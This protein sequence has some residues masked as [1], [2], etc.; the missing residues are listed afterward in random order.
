MCMQATL[1]VRGLHCCFS[2]CSSLS[3]DYYSYHAIDFCVSIPCCCVIKWE[4]ALSSQT[5]TI[6]CVG[7]C[8]ETCECV[9]QVT[10]PSKLTLIVY[11]CVCMDMCVCT[12]RRVCEC[13][14]VVFHCVSVSLCFVWL[15]KPMCSNILCYWFLHDYLCTPCFCLIKWQRVLSHGTCNINSI[16][17]ITVW[18]YNY[19]MAQTSGRVWHFSSVY[20]AAVT[21]VRNKCRT[22]SQR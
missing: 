19:I 9:C 21:W 11:V 16:L 4:S 18:L 15:S 1:W 10:H 5:C 22:S 17:L 3:S 13:K 8:M 20:E 2:V 14:G 12:C 6:M 7:M